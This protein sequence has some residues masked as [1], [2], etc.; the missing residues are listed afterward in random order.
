MKDSFFN[1]LVLISSSSSGENLEA[2]NKVEKDLPQL[3]CTFEEAMKKYPITYE[4]PINLGFA[5]EV[6]RYE[7]VLSRIKESIARARKTFIFEK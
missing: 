5:Q 2:I 4:E 6:K 1:N 7:M 3:V